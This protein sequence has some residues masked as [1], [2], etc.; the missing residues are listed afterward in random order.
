MSR[1]VRSPAKRKIHR[2]GRIRLEGGW[3]VLM[4][5]W[6]TA[7]GLTEKIPYD[8]S[9]D[10]RIVKVYIMRNLLRPAYDMLFVRYIQVEVDGGGKE[11]L[12]VHSGW[13]TFVREGMDVPEGL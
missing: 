5:A 2:G 12:P 7:V 4:P 3:W 8:G 10:G 1:Y 6:P 9:L 13:D 11:W